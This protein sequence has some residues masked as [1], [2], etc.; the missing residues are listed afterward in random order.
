[1]VYEKAC[2]EGRPVEDAAANQNGTRTNGDCKYVSPKHV[3][4]MCWIATSPGFI[5][6][7]RNFSAAMVPLIKSYCNKPN[8][9]VR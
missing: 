4:S 9:A 2:V 7:R 3:L 5:C 6:Q 1:M 8:G